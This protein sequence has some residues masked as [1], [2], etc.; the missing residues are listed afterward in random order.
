MNDITKLAES[1]AELTS[2]QRD[3]WATRMYY[4]AMLGGSGFISP[5]LNLFYQRQGLSGV[6]I[7]WVV[8]IS[9]LVAIFAAPTWTNLVGRHSRPRSLLQGSLVVSALVML[10]TGWQNQLV[11]IGLLTAVRTMVGAG[12]APL[13]DAVAVR[14]VTTARTGYGSVRVWGSL[15][16]A[17]LVL[18]SGWL[19][20]K[21]GFAAGFWGYALAISISAGLVFRIRPE[22]FHRHA[23]ANPKAGYS[24]A[25]SAIRSNPVLIGLVC[26][27]ILTGMANAG[28]LQFETIYLTQLGA[29]GTVL[30]LAS[31]V[32]SV[33]ELFG[34]FWADRMVT[35]YGTSI[36]LKLSMLMY[37]FLRAA[38]FF[39][40]G[41]GS[42]IAERALGGLAFSLI[43]VGIVRIIVEQ[44]R[45]EQTATILALFTVTL[46]GLVGILAN[47]LAGFLFDS[48]G[49]RWLYPISAGGYLLAW[50][51]LQVTRSKAAAQPVVTPIEENI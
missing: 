33:V 34:M 47:P 17:I 5:F 15:G 16:W 48:L 1:D 23:Q 18:F 43:T 27:Y 41:V 38:I 4:F 37:A 2:Q 31:M 3:L 46:V 22:L 12:I 28:V 25:I 42:I 10:W 45:P 51:A 39:I 36:T 49:P 13:S 26:M 8:A 35:R 14:V 7:G 20:E 30:G 21:L 40:P 50:V 9:A 32:S 29:W 24:Q 6:E 11:S 44:T 19:I